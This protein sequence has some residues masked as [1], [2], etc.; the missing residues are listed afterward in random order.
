MVPV[1]VLCNIVESGFEPLACEC[2]ESG[3]LLRIEV[4]DPASGQVKLLIAGV[5]IEELTSVRVIS[6]FIGELRAE[7]SAGRRA[8]AG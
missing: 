5:S 7:M 3:G 4:F 8:F 6:E 2:T 1:S